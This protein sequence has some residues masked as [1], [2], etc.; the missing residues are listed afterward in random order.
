M[1]TVSAIFFFL[2]FLSLSIFIHELGHLLVA[3]WR[4]KYVDKFS[5]GFGPILWSKKICDIEYSLR[6]FPLG[7]FVSIPQLDIFDGDEKKKDNLGNTLSSPTAWDRILIAIAGPIMNI[8]FAFVLALIVSISG[9]EMEPNSHHLKIESIPKDSS[10]YKAGLRKGDIITK[11]NGEQFRSKK[12][13]SEKVILNQSS[14]VQFEYLRNDNMLSTEKFKLESNPLLHGILFYKFSVFAIYDNL[15]VKI[16]KVIPNSSAE[17]I[18]LLKDDVIL[19]INDEK[20]DSFL[21]V[22]MIFNKTPSPHKIKIMRGKEIKEFVS[23]TLKSYKSSSLGILLNNNFEIQM[24][25]NEAIKNLK[26]NDQILKI[27]NKELRNPE[28]I[29]NLKIPYQSTI[30][31]TFMREGIVKE[32]KVPII[33][34]ENKKIGI[35]FFMTETKYPSAWSQ[36]IRAIDITFSSIYSLFN[37]QSSI[38]IEHMSSIIGIGK[39]VYQQV[40]TQGIVA[41]LSIMILI[42]VGLALFNLLPIPILDGGHISLGVIQL[43]FR[44]SV[45]AK[46]IRPI[47]MLFY[48]ALLALMFYTITNDILRWNFDIYYL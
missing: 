14:T 31:V 36:V 25:N 40:S 13:F 38:G 46:F 48:V 16:S 5:V 30:L 17:S 26:I 7:G 2:L 6:L 15:L 34:K 24:I 4:K 8:L 42:N 11:F 29:K 47:M 35:I 39:V 1:L 41:G 33:L 20:I 12:D 27:D 18:G 32:S 37:P 9:K 23:N 19:S 10:S 43:I 21:E 28:D 45:P 22:S 44:R 3:L